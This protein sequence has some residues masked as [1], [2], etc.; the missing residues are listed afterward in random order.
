[1]GLL[2]N[3]QIY[4]HQGYFVTTHSIHGAVHALTSCIC[5][6]CDSVSVPLF[7]QYLVFESFVAIVVVDPSWTSANEISAEPH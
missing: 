6:V 1:M 3:M 4:G 7:Y 2:G 5:G